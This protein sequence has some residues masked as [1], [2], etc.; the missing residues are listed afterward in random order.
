MFK[1][2]VDNSKLGKTEKNELKIVDTKQKKLTWKEGVSGEKIWMGALTAER[3]AKSIAQH[4]EQS[5]T[6]HYVLNGK[7]M[8]FYGEGYKSS[9]KLNEGDFIYIPPYQSYMF[10]NNSDSEKL[11][12]VTTMAP[13]YQ[14]TYVDQNEIVVSKGVAND[15]E[16]ISVIKASDLRDSTNQTN[17][18][19]RKTAVQAP[20]LWIGRVTG[21]A[22]MDSGRHHHGE[23][24]T[25][26]FI[27]S[28]TTQLL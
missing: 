23:A 18:M 6:V 15:E 11:H 26:G 21:E 2:K 22:A 8:F 12:I 7:A 13:S 14:V 16:G 4:H 9:V 25:S 10:Q 27:I 3:S 20:N 1:S 28:G 5:D 24:E 19:P 17:N